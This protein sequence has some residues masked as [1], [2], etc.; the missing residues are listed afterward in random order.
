MFIALSLMSSSASAAPDQG[1]LSTAPIANPVSI[2][3]AAYTGTVAEHVAQLEASIVVNASEP[4]QKVFLF[5]DDVAVQQFSS[6]PSDAK[7][8]RE[9]TGV[10]VMLPRRG[11]CTLQL[12]LLVK[13]GG[14]VTK[15]QLAFAIPGAMTS[16]LALTI[17]QPDADVEFPA[18]ISVKRATAGQQTRLEAVM[19]SGERVELFWT[20]RVKRAAEIAANVICH[21]ATL[22]SFGGGVLNARAMLNYQV[23]QGEMR[24]ARVRLPAA[25]RL[26]RV[27][28]EGIRT[29]EVNS[30]TQGQIL[31]VEL[32]K[33]IASTCQLTIETEKVLNSLP[34]SVKA[35][36]PHVMGVNRETGLVALRADEE[37]E[38]AV[39]STAELYRVDIEEFGRLTGQKPNGIL[40][41]FRF[42]KP[43]FTLQIRIAAMQPE[44]EAVL[45]N[46]IRV[47]PEQVNLTSVIDYTIKRAGVFGLKVAVPTGYHLES[48]SGSNILQ[49][50]ERIEADQQIMEVTLNQRT[51][52]AYSLRF[53]LAQRL[54]E[55]PKTLGIVGVHPLGIQ[56]LSGFILVS[57]EPGVALKAGAF[58]GLSEIPVA[59]LGATDSDTSGSSLAYKFIATE[60]QIAPA[61][62]L[63]VETEAV[64]SW[65]RAEFVNTLT[66]SDTHIS[67]RAI[68]RF[69]IQNAPV[70]ELRLRVP[71][72]FKNVEISG[73]NIRRRDHNGD[74]WNVSFQSKIRGTHT[75]T[76][77]WEEPRTTK[78]NFLELR[79]VAAD[80]VERNTGI[81]AIV[82][83]PPL[84][85]TGKSAENLKPIDLRDLPDWA[86]QPEE[87]T[88]LA[89]RYVRS[90]YKLGVEASRFAEA[91]VLQ[92]LV[93]SL[94]LSTVVAD[95]GQMMTEMSLSVRNQGRQH[96][97]IALPAGAMVWSA[98]VAGQA[99]RPSLNA[100]KLLLPLEHSL[101]DD[102]A[103]PIELVYV[104]TN[105]FPQSRG[106]VE[107]ISPKLDAPLKSTRWEL[108]LP[109]DYS[110]SDF[111]GTM[112]HEVETTLVEAADF[113]FLDYSSRESK[114]KAELAKELK[115]ELRSAQ[116]KLSSG[117]VKEALVDFNRARNKGDLATA[118]N[119]ETRQ[120]EADLRRAQGNNLIEA[121]NS[122]SLSNGGNWN[123]IQQSGT[124]TQA[125]RYDAAA[126]EAQ[127]TK[128]QQAQDLGTLNV[129]PIRVNLPTRGQRH[130]FTQVLQTE[131][132]KPLTI[133]M[134][135]TN[136]RTISWPKRIT[137]PLAG[138]L[139]LW[140]MV[141]LLKRRANQPTRRTS[142]EAY[143]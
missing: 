69:D 93:E 37:L 5:S 41:A 89:Y 86:G 74:I 108:F 133:R 91:E 20:P 42:L 97:E 100:G 48:M 15:R 109:A 16:Q 40:N 104:D 49:T 134:M 110:Y 13:L 25:H 82:A 33:G 44:I 10:A 81:L 122:F 26:L 27:E 63:A 56:K 139:V 136:T 28:G 4:N 115:S 39:E 95:D 131:T 22:V 87:A 121:Q 31:E 8:V 78:T 46:N 34:V 72:S 36:V 112:V 12:K 68:A 116:K 67:G 124:N 51:S 76:I 107:L 3:S 23:T 45:H 64:E 119:S 96:L 137:G 142:G 18:A 101:G 50:T 19:G 113:S 58:D 140:F 127:W 54:K 43:D 6:K 114:S 123:Q 99:V 128:L 52:G 141:S 125:L 62:N 75:L 85:V 83:R 138:F 130:G 90:D 94:N 102:S 129:Q 120:L 14:D 77:T 17:D 117:N 32:L 38:L 29:W 84:Q 92:T 55:L 70:R 60:P 59:L 21:N 53:E 105:V 61:W 71:A 80:N 65:V 57:V 35:E 9:A 24:Q 2:V 103:I 98:F 7:L 88:V 73:A 47:S 106:V 111:S 126:A 66:L 79:G 143:L 132:G 11:E 118:N 30:D 135:A 1:A